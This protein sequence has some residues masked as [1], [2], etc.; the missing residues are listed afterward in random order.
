MINE[1][2]AERIK[3]LR[4]DK[5][6]SQKKLGDLVGVSKVSI[7][8][9]ENSLQLPS[10]EIL[11]LLAKALNC[12]VDYLLGVNPNNEEDNIHGSFCLQSFCCG[13][14]SIFEQYHNQHLGS[15]RYIPICGYGWCH[16]CPWCRPLGHQQQSCWPW[17]DFQERGVLYGRSLLVGQQ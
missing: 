16:G 6:Y 7:F 15:L 8:N 3:S 11:V 4:Q 13:S 2:F 14:G 9:Y 5:G 17:Y 10:V 12:S 1:L